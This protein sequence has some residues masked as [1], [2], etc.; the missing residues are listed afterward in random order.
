MSSPL[1]SPMYPPPSI[2]DDDIPQLYLVPITPEQTNALKGY[3]FAVGQVLTEAYVLPRSKAE[4]L[5]FMLGEVVTVASSAFNAL[6][7]ANREIARR[8][9]GLTEYRP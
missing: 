8:N 1:E 3:W 4:T 6:L 2:G 9:K 7:L 5:G